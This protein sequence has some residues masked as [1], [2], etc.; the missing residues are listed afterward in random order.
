MTTFFATSTIAAG[1]RDFVAVGL[2]I[3]V[4]FAMTAAA[5]TDLNGALFVI[6]F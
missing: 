2:A 5:K 3:V 6:W 4:P 1:I